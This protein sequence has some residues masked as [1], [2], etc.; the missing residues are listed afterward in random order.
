MSQLFLGYLDPQVVQIDQ[1][2]LENQPVQ[3]DQ[4]HRQHQKVQQVRKDQRVLIGQAVQE[5][6]GLQQVHL[7]LMDRGVLEG[8]PV[9][10]ALVVLL[11]LV[12]LLHHL[13]EAQERLH[14]QVSQVAQRFLQDLYLLQDQAVL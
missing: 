9:H 3:V 8:Q 7:D 4:F 5:I 6:R 12:L 1:L 13:P 14:F 11:L 2:V 10:L